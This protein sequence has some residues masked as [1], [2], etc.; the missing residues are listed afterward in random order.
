MLGEP[1]PLKTG[2][3]FTIGL[4]SIFLL[5]GLLN[6]LL[7][8]GSF[9][10]LLGTPIFIYYYFFYRKRRQ[11]G[12]NIRL[13]GPGGF[14]FIL[15]LVSAILILFVYVYFYTSY[16]P[17]QDM[18]FGFTPFFLGSML[19]IA[20]PFGIFACKERKILDYFMKKVV[21]EY[22]IAQISKQTHTK[23][24]KVKKTI[25]KFIK[26]K[27]IQGKM[28]GNKFI[29]LD[30]PEEINEMLSKAKNF[31]M[32]NNFV[33][34]IEVYQTAK[35]FTDVVRLYNK[36]AG[37]HEKRNDLD[38]AMKYYL[39]AH[40]EKGVIHIQKLRINTLI[41]QNK[42]EM[43]AKLCE[44]IG[45]WETAGELRRGEI[46]IEAS[47]STKIDNHP[48]AGITYEHQVQ[49]SNIV[50]PVSSKSTPQPTGANWDFSELGA[51]TR[52]QKQ[53]VDQVPIV[54][55]VSTQS[56]SLQ[57]NPSFETIPSSLVS[58]IP[59]YVLT[60]KIGS[61]GFATV[62][63]AIAPTGECFAV[64]LPKLMDSTIDMSVLDKFKAESEIWRKLKHKNIVTFYKGD[65]RPVPYIIIEYMEGGNLLTMLKAGL[66]P[67]NKSIFVIHEIL[68][69][70]AYAH[71]M[72]SVHRD[73]KPEN[74]LFTMEGTPKVADWGIGKFMASESTSKTIGTK[75]TLAYSAPEQVSREKYGQVDW[76]TDVF[77][78]GIVFYEMLCGINPFM[79]DD[80][81]GIINNVINKVPLPPS[82]LRADI[83]PAIDSIVLRALEKEKSKRFRSADSMLE[84]LEESLR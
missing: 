68:L 38:K 35:S 27:W 82:S 45:E 50:P 53:F 18:V 67:L 60:N 64:K 22:K 51:R 8:L 11:R 58:L 62:Y 79:A 71:R 47:Y 72:A 61:G 84:K 44:E 14:F 2:K 54:N 24:K 15:G 49:Q 5:A 78:L 26:R 20:I 17:L 52:T 56:F 41:A 21:V 81:I 31:E 33:K 10:F 74:I 30:K 46:K 42:I 43:A 23:E 28:E 36:I 75:G 7:G 9:I 25:N 19:I 29:R 57:Q 3:V 40:N 37:E 39:K 70:M 34:A 83:P 12:L 80:P 1:L 63:K 4:V 6:F 55:V 69:G 13:N 66:L 76:T 48:T 32:A 77:Q 73:I 59:G 65:I 16:A